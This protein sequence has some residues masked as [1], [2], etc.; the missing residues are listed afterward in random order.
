MEL[1]LD[2]AKHVLLLGILPIPLAL[3]LAQ[4]LTA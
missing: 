4:S 3:I 1:V 2:F